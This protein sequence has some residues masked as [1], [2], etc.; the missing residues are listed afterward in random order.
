MK[1]KTTKSKRLYGLLS[2]LSPE[3]LAD[4]LPEASNSPPVSPPIH[5]K[6][7]HIR[8]IG[9]AIAI[10]AA[11]A[12]LFLGALFLLPRLFNHQ[13]LQLTPLTDPLGTLLPDAYYRADLIWANEENLLHTS[14]VKG[15]QAPG[16]L[17]ISFSPP[18]NASE[19]TRYAVRITI[20]KEGN[21]RSAD[22]N[23]YYPL[24]MQDRKAF[25][26]YLLSLGCEMFEVGE[27]HSLVTGNT[28][29]YY[30]ATYAQ[31]EAIDPT[32]LYNTMG[33]NLTEIPGICVE[34]GYQ[35]LTPYEIPEYWTPDAKTTL[36]TYWK[37]RSN[38]GSSSDSLKLE[39]TTPVINQSKQSS[40]SFT[41]SHEPTSCHEFYDCKQTHTFSP[42]YSMRLQVKLNNQW[43]FVPISTTSSAVTAKEERSLTNANSETITLRLNELYGILPDGYYRVE[44]YTHIPFTQFDWNR[45]VYAAFV[46]NNHQQARIVTNPE[47]DRV[48]K[49]EV[50]AFPAYKI[51]SLAIGTTYQEITAM[52]GAP[53][54]DVT[55]E[56]KVFQHP[57]QDGFPINLIYEYSDSALRLTG[58]EYAIEKVTDFPTDYYRPDLIWANSINTDALTLCSLKYTMHTSGPLFDLFGV[59]DCEERFITMPDDPTAY[60]VYVTWEAEALFETDQTLPK[61]YDQRI[62]KYLTETIGLIPLQPNDSLE[63]APTPTGYYYAATRKQLS[64]ISFDFMTSVDHPRD[65]SVTLSFHLGVQPLHPTNQ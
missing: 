55:G 48:W 28:G 23:E 40:V 8:R 53:I 17:Y 43:Y 2:E 44:L 13:D 47:N 46:V 35:L 1:T 41:L 61:D 50:F 65:L 45:T 63:L 56:G 54:L 6:R 36:Y 59:Y 33:L 26:N 14:D 18:H 25:Q 42:N 32:T 37:Q 24:S 64:S 62:H 60:A 49:N 20:L 9:R 10:Y 3:L 16:Q 5:F 11:C 7:P 52:L 21:L 57:T 12:M 34:L 22:K 58:M 29:I 31:I 15:T 39:T 38:T 4:A 19:D 51:E 27:C 30:A